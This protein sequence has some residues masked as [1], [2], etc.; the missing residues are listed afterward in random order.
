MKT[1]SKFIYALL[2]TGIFFGGGIAMQYQ[3]FSE[4]KQSPDSQVIFKEPTSDFEQLT[5]QELFK[6]FLLRIPPEDRKSFSSDKYLKQQ[7]SVYDFYLEMILGNFR[8]EIRDQL[9]KSNLKKLAWVIE[10]DKKTYNI[11][12]CINIRILLQNISED[13]ITVYYPLLERGFLLRS[14]SL[15]KC[16]KIEKTRVYLT[17]G[18]YQEYMFG[19]GE[20]S[21]RGYKTFLLKPGDK[22]PTFQTITHLNPHYDL[23]LSGDYELTFYTRNFL[24]GDEKQIGEYPKPCTIRFTIEAYYTEKLD[25]QIVW[26]DDGK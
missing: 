21:P 18:A 24:E 16:G 20:A 22:A 17:Q 25:N 6:A 13:E 7:Q 4:D 23:S 26:P 2:Y 3:C 5:N 19:G 14:M 12:E 1:K 15:K 10:T 11:G 8:H 9:D